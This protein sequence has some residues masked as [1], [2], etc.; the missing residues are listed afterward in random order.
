MTGCFPIAALP[1]DSALRAHGGEMSRSAHG[2]GIAIIRRSEWEDLSRTIRGG[3]SRPG[4]PGPGSSPC[5]G[6]KSGRK[7]PVPPIPWLLRNPPFR[8]RRNILCF[9]KS[10][11]RPRSQRCR[12]FL[13]NRKSQKCRNARNALRSRKSQKCRSI[14]NARNAR[15]APLSRKHR[16]NQRCR[17]VR[18][19]RSIPVRPVIPALARLAAS[20]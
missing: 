18:D 15:S 1:G 7:K 17:S 19:V 4:I 14:R 13:R 16:K 9:Q 3:S 6:E 11:R 5:P 8:K 12:K 2:R 10:R 20:Q